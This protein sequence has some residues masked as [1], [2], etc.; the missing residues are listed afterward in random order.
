MTKFCKIHLNQMTIFYIKRFIIKFICLFIPKKKW[1]KAIRNKFL[2]NPFGNLYDQFLEIKKKKQELYKKK[3]NIES[4]FLGSSHA[5]FGFDTLEFGANS[6][7]LGS[8][9]QDL[10]TSYQLYNKIKDDLPNL[11]NIFLS[12]SVFS[13]GWCLA[14]ADAKHICH[15]YKYLYDIDYDELDFSDKDKKDCT[16]LDSI[17]IKYKQTNGFHPVKKLKLHQTVKERI[18]GH[19]KSHNRTINQLSEL[20]N[21]INQTKDKNFYIVFMPVNDEYRKLAP[22]FADIFGEICKIADEHNIKYFNF[23]DDTDFIDTDFLDCDHLNQSGAKKLSQKLKEM[24]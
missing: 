17:H 18:E 2:G 7:N 14:K 3:E 22:S 24:L 13:K 20:Y 19:L 5:A 6:F 21:F 12:Y 15:S 23:Y 9:S 11:K 16:D 4:I 8:N 10:Y 1:R